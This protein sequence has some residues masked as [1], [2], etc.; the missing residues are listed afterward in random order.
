MNYGL[1]TQKS[2]EKAENYNKGI[3][4]TVKP[5]FGKRILEV[6]SSIG[7]L[8]QYF[9]DKDLVVST[10]IS[11]EYVEAIK[12]R[13]S[14]HKNFNAFVFDGADKKILS[15]KK[16]K[17]D[18]ILCF[19]V[20]EHIEDDTQTLNNFH[21]LL[22]KNGCL[23]LLVPCHPILYGTLDSADGHFRR[24]TK[25]EL[26]EKFSKTG[27]KVE[28]MHYINFLGMFGWLFNGKVLKKKTLP[29]NQLSFY[30]KLVPFLFS[31][32]KFLNYPTGQSI[33]C[34][35]RKK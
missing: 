2:L 17:F 34:I 11:K 5:F 35:G 1:E 24:Y 26:L 21:N 28:K 9:L 25:K 7:N 32:E 6:G 3:I 8:T 20:L 16:N 14:E 23:L 31:L 29:R 27:F 19:N 10:D 12:K 22:E 4:E 13:Y 33:V 30:D 15:L 18:T